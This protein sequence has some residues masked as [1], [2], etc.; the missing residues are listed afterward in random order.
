MTSQIPPRSG[1]RPMDYR[2]QV[3]TVPVTDVEQALQEIGHRPRTCR[4]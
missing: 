1:R 3:V 4:D 2:I